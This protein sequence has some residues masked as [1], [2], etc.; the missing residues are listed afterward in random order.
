MRFY[1]LLSLNALTVASLYFLVASGFSLIFGLLRTVN[2]AH[3][4][5][6]L[7]G[8]YVGYD[9]ASYTGPGCS[10][11]GA[12]SP[13]PSS[14]GDAPDAAAHAVRRAAAALVTIGFPSWSA[15][16]CWPITR[17]HLPVHPR[18]LYARRPAVSRLPD[19][20]L[21]VIASAL[22]SAGCGC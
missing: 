4:A 19:I 5:F 22:L 1:I 20:R 3:G 21:V 13:W 11:G 8:A 7:L 17:H 16:C 18:I 15:T 6:Y 9:I 12:A 14:A 2:M 10:A